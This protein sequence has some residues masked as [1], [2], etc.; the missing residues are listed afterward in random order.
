[1]SII[2]IFPGQGSQRLGMGKALFKKFPKLVNQADIQLGY[3]IEELCLED[4]HKNLHQTQFTQPALYVVNALN[5]L[6][7]VEETGTPPDFVAGHSLGEYNALF[8]AGVFDFLTGLKLIQKRGQL[9]DEVSG[10]AMAAVIGLTEEKIQ[11]IIVENSLSG[12]D[13]ANLNDYTQTVIAGSEEEIQAAQDLFRRAGAKYVRL[14]VSAAFHSRHMKSVQEKFAKFLIDFSFQSPKIPVIANVTALPYQPN[15]I[16]E[17]LTDQIVTS[18][19]WVECVEYLLQQSEPK[20]I[21]VGPGQVLTELVNKIRSK[22]Q[23]KTLVTAKKDKNI[24]FMYPGQGSQYYHMGK[25][26]YENNRIFRE[27]MQKLNDTVEPCVGVSILDILYKDSYR[28][29]EFSNIL[30]THPANFMISY[31][32]TQLVYDWEIYPDYLL[33]YSL[34]EYTAAAVAGVLKW[35]EI[36]NL[37]VKQARLV[38]ETPLATMV[39]IL[40]SPELFYQLQEQ[41]K[42]CWLAA[43][44]FPKHFVISIKLEDLELLEMFLKR[45]KIVFQKLPVAQGFHCPLIDSIEIPLKKYLRELDQNTPQTPVISCFSGI[46]VDWRDNDH[47]WNVIRQPVEFQKTVETFEKQYDNNVYLDLGASGTM[48]NF[49]KYNLSS[50][51]H[52]TFVSMMNQFGQNIKSTEQARNQLQEIKQR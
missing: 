42:Q 8:A 7:K 6:E 29:K 32:L 12:I 20:F 23:P 5:Y 13:I 4:P 14:K 35:E 45:Q 15:K 37:L 21:E 17:N 41:L 34:G 40:G 25:E 22:Y 48:A 47:L 16:V 39:A 38:Q 24:I 9:M 31:S 19:R 36:L 50:Q 43:H 2:Y 52:S 26:L 1:M 46:V 30:Y 51:T 28:S 44:N 11:E 33:G 49:V 3:S 10:S 27:W 18:V